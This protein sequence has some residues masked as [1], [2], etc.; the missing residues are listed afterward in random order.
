MTLVILWQVT[1]EHAYTHDP[2]KS[3]LTM[4]LSKHGVG[5]YPETSSHATC[6]GT[7]GQSSP[8]TE[9]LWTDPG[10]KRGISASELISTSKNKTKNSVGRE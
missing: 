1:P 7:S 5:T 8:L 4:S 2:M 3:E 9:P 6:Q 10:L